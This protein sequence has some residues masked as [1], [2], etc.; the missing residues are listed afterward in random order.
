MKRLHTQRLAKLL[1]FLILMAALSV[2]PSSAPAQQPAGDSL[3]ALPPL[4]PLRQSPTE[5]AEKDGTA[6][7]IS[8]KDLTK[9]ALQNNLDIAISDTNEE[10][11]HQG[12]VQAFGQY[13]PTL[14]VGLGVNSYKYPNTNFSTKS[15]QGNYNKVDQANWNFQ[16]Q[17]NVRTG[18]YFTANYNSS[19]SDTNQAFSLFSPQYNATASVSF[20]Q[21]LRRNLRIDQN[22]S[23][24]LLANLDLKT[25]DSQ[26]KQKVVETIANIQGQYWDLV[27]A[28]RDYDIKRESVRVAQ[29]TL[30]DNRRKLEIG[31]I[32]AITVTEAQAT[33]SQ[34]EVDL[35]SAE[36][37]VYNAENALRALISNDRNAE[38][39]RKFIVP[40][41]TPDFQEYKVDPDAAIDTALKNR[42][43]L[44]QLDLGLQRYDINQK[45]SENLRKWQVDLRAGFGSTGVAGPQSIITDPLT[46]QSIQAIDPSLVGSIGRS[47]QLLF[48]GGYI[49]WTVGFN[50]VI[51]LRNRTAEAS[52]AQAKIGKRQQIMRRK[53]T[54][55]QINVE[56]RNAIQKIETSRQQVDTARMAR[57]FAKEQLDGEEKRF[58]NGVSENFRVLDRQSN[59]A[60][61]QGVEL[62]A[63]ITYK[64]SVIAF[65]KATYT[66]LDSNDFR[67]AKTSSDNVP[68]SK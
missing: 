6:L 30:R 18:G 60:Q 8:M 22:R 20:T 40:T 29:I 5:K 14:T 51:P 59:L 33:A 37:R 46:G 21:P 19:R 35:I 39:W 12:V 36:E 68:N 65:Q 44:E 66:L 1:V 13:D 2:L 26:F 67:I 38:I 25:N 31:T 56:V 42:P 27:G 11:Y 52:L 63:L 9:L 4:P 53:N 50:V 54:E 15:T 41:E 28:I 62:Q 23:T 24:I 32:A 16:F 7:R 55:Q 45:M 47:Y 3:G 61:A 49:N 58:Q 43:E 48:T 64:K 57:Q 34:R 10:F 17:Q